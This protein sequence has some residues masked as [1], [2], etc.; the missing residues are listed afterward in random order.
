M[1]KYVMCYVSNGYHAFY[2][3]HA[4]NRNAPAIIKSIDMLSLKTSY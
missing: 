2:L 4:D 3:D 1:K